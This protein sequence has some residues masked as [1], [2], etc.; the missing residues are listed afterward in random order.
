MW[1]LPNSQPKEVVVTSKPDALDQSSKPVTLSEQA[2]PLP[3][4]APERTIY[5]E[6]QAFYITLIFFAAIALRVLLFVLG[7]YG[8][9]GRAM[10]PD[11]FRYIELSEAI[12]GQGAFGLTSPEAGVVHEPLYELRK[13][14]GQLEPT[15]D[16][17]LRPEIM[18][19]PGYPTL[20]GTSAWLG[21]GFN[22][23]LLLQCL[24][25]AVSVTLVYGIGRALL[26]RPGPALFAAAVVAVHPAAIAAPTAI[27]TE[28]CFTLLILLGLW[29]VADRE[30]RGIGSTTFGGLMIGL[31]VLVRPVSIFLGP[32]IALWMIVTDR[33]LKTFVLAIL[34]LALS[35]APGAAWMARN[36]AVGFGYR[37]SS[38]PYINTYFYGNAYMRITEQGGDWKQDWPATVDTLM[39]ELRAEQNLNPD[40]DVYD[41]MK[42][43]GVEAIREDP[44]LYGRVYK[45]SMLK[46]FT[47]HSLGGLYQQLGLTYT[48]TGLR[49]K[50]MT[51]GLSWT[52]VSESLKNP[53]GWL[54][55]AWVGFNGLLL[56]G[57]ILGTVM[58]LVRGHF[59]ALLL[60][61]GVMFYFALAT[62]T[63]GLERFRLPVLGV[64]ALLVASLF[65]PKWPREK[66]AKSPKRRWY[67]RDD[68][69]DEPDA[70]NA[71]AGKANREPEPEPESRARPI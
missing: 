17:G 40:A 20:L 3:V 44:G 32:A 38:I 11:S 49:D 28:T 71:D 14:L 58:L 57:M 8:D 27:L 63:T 16:G 61:G 65:A 15:M 5:D 9:S 18:R 6:S 29:S 2:K 48:P 43:L 50:L 4:E 39:S 33:R 12:V 31:S 68:A 26:K 42:N 56:I 1:F 19:T 60:L 37:L 21:L 35:L 25:S 55:V 54:A 24:F 46:L 64:Q 23:L 62:Q 7:P 13:D 36:E 66:N 69:E 59:S 45:E 30:T 22:G 34:M 47:D 52:N 10:Y 41:S 67:E 51:G 70:D 53:T